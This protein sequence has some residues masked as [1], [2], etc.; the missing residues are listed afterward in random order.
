MELSMIS[1]QTVSMEKL[2]FELL[3]WYSLRAAVR[4]EKDRLIGPKLKYSLLPLSDSA[5]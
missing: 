2:V 4:H 3:F 5:M 1:Q